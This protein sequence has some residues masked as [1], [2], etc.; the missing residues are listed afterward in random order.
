M[1]AKFKV[2][3]SDLRSP[4][5]SS[6]FKFKNTSRVKHLETVIGQKR[7]VSA[8]EFGLNMKSPGYN[9]FVT[10]YEGTGK[11]TIV[12][13]LVKTHAKSME[14]SC[15]WCMINNFKDAFVPK[16]IALPPGMAV[17]FKKRMI[18]FVDALKKE[19][20][21]AFADE[22]YNENRNKIQK[23][24]KEHQRELFKQL[25]EYARE[26]NM[27]I[28]K[29]NTGF[30]PVPT[31]EGKEISAE[32]YRDLS[33]K[34]QRQMEDN[35]L[36]VRE[37]IEGV[38]R[39]VNKIEQDMNEEI[40]SLRGMITL[41][42]INGRM[43][44]IKTDFKDCPDVLSY[45]DEIR[46]DVV[47][48][49]DKFI[50]AQSSGNE[51]E[52]MAVQSRKAFFRRY[53]VNVLV[54]RGNTKGAPVI[55]ETSPRYQNVFG[56]I[57]KRTNMGTVT[58]D[59]A[60]VQAGSLLKANGGY[61]LME[62]ESVLAYPLVWD[63][64]KRALQNKLLY[65][66]DAPMNSGF[67]MTSLRPEPIPLSVKVILYGGYLAFQALQNKDAKFNKIF[68]VRADFDYEVEKT[69]ETLDQYV[70]FLARACSQESLL[71]LDRSGVFAMVEFGERYA[72]KKNKLSIRFGPIVAMLKEANYW[73]E[74]EGACHISEEH[75][76][77]AFHEYRFRHSLYEEKLHENYTE[78]SIIIDVE[79]AVTGQ[80]NALSV[81]RV[82]DI[83]FGRP[84]RITAET[85][86]G[87]SGVINIER[88]VNLSG[89]T[90]DKGV[91]IISGY[92][93]R[94]FAQKY[95]LSLTVSIAFEQNYAGID[96]DSA[97]ST[98]LYA[99]LSSLSGIP[100]KQ[101]I[102][103]TGSVNQK[104]EIQSIGGVNEKIEGFFE[105]C[106][107]KGL[108]GK[109]G[110]IIPTA[111]VSNLQL[112]KEVVASVKKRKFHIYSVSDITEGIEI[113]TGKKAGVPDENG[114]Y[115]GT[116]VYG[117]VQQK[118]Y[119]FL[120]QAIALKKMEISS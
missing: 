57:E 88:E 105:V 36:A 100:V 44:I 99:I 42:V 77:K 49:V 8:I 72:A 85:Y 116:S 76:E 10:G 114:N 53:L 43:D 4:R 46:T 24:F 107:S 12:R 79:G 93:G 6:K 69:P 67:G 102:A 38:L 59:Y 55:Y 110:V 96:G 78:N 118:L 73:A 109:Q 103:V 41:F 3:T 68:K 65:I 71:P 74:K 98:E 32:D 16:T 75:V 117:M 104:G 113:L 61:L 50:P 91:L 94:T 62:I 34:E 11:S 30:H 112:N 120:K 87:K 106:K 28:N 60:M 56:Q 81:Y 25:E 13:N 80:V 97:S 19:L 26:R 95:P 90:H 45:M 2:K 70:Q 115:P 39:D 17:L 48:N 101:G 29:T 84:S 52:R 58:T 33:Q 18:K 22:V 82:G 51:K 92:M 40:E 1:S 89:R 86:M 5:A 66:E 9:I 64:L 63:G 7:A 21:K 23:K 54:D 108:T 111:N 31:K 35:G 37:R 47:D 15:D 14:P 119:L 20:P 83:S 27:M